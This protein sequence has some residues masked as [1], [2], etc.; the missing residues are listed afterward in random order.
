MFGGGTADRELLQW[1]YPEVTGRDQTPAEVY[2][3]MRVI[4]PKRYGLGYLFSIYRR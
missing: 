4:T 2:G 3:A 1:S